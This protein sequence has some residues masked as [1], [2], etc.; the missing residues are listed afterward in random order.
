MNPIVAILLG[1]TAAL[2]GGFAWIVRWFRRWLVKQVTEPIALLQRTI[3]EAAARA[4]SAHDR[5]DR[6]LE[7]HAHG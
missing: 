1:N 4:N 7:G 3:D 6:H 5:L 2:L